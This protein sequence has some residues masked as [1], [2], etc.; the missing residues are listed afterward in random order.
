MKKKE[1]DHEKDKMIVQTGHATF[2]RQTNVISTGNIIANTMIGWHCRPYNETECNGWQFKPGHLREFDLKKWKERGIYHP[3]LAFVRNA[4][5]ADKSI[6]IY[7]FFHYNDD[8]RIVHGYVITSYN[9]KILR[10]FITGPTYRSTGVIYE[11]A[12]YV[13][14]EE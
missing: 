6:W 1:W 9:H 2:D 8:T 7:E 5:Q 13:G 14:D 10:K 3:V 12:K 4:T 11:C